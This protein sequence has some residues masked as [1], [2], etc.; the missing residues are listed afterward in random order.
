MCVLYVQSS[1]ET[2]MVIIDFYV[3]FMGV[4]QSEGGV[5]RAE[6]HQITAVTPKFDKNGIL[7]LRKKRLKHNRILL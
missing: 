7:I 2:A 6:S 3:T 4:G 1:Y 5:I